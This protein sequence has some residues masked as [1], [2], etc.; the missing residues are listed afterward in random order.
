MAD[1]SCN[2]A[3]PQLHPS[4]RARFSPTRFDARAAVSLGQVDLLLD[5]ARLAPSAGNSQPWRFIV[6][7]RGDGVHARIIRHLAA[8]TARWAPEASVLIVNLAHVRVEGTTWPFS[9][10]AHYDLGQAVAHMTVQGMIMGLDSHQ[11]RGFDRDGLTAEFGVPNDWEVTSATA[12]GV[13]AHSAGELKGPGTSRERYTRAEV[14][15]ARAN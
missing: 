5:A 6:G 15:W 9:E 4:L 12:F 14:T 7:R 8:S 2:D 13:A 3:V 11:F 10:F 1:M